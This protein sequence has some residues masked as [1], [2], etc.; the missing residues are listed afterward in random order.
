M[1]KDN[2]PISYGP[3]RNRKIATITFSQYAYA[4]HHLYDS[5]NISKTVF[6]WFTVH[7]LYAVWFG[8]EASEHTHFD[9]TCVHYIRVKAHAFHGKFTRMLFGYHFMAVCNKESATMFRFCITILF[10]LSCV[11]FIFR[12]YVASFFSLSLH[13][14]CCRTWCEYQN[15]LE[16]PKIDL[17]TRNTE[18][19]QQPKNDNKKNAKTLKI[20]E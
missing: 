8:I 20:V 11:R 17:I 14:I 13:F 6:T 3:R 7:V 9:C 18:Q 19:Q 5:S 16:K 4:W 10:S 12:V 1:C 15:T 2:Q